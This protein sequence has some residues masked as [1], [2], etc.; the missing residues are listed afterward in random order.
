MCLGLEAIL[1]GRLKQ[2][3]ELFSQ[4]VTICEDRGEQIVVGVTNSLWTHVHLMRGETDRAYALADATLQRVQHAGAGLSLGI[5]QQALG[6]AELA[7][8]K[9]AAAREHLHKAVNTDRYGLIFGFCW[10]LVGL[11][12][13]ERVAGNLQAAHDHGQEALDHARRLGSG[14]MQAGAERLLARLALAA[15]NTS[16]AKRYAGNALMRL[17]V[18]GL[19]LDIP[20]CLD[21]HAA[22]AAAQGD[23]DQAARLFGAA[24]TNRQSLGIIRFPPEPEFWVSVEHTTE[25]AL[26]KDRYRTAYTQGTCGSI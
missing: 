8:G 9:L 14:W 16:E 25:D 21:I 12:A 17:Q 15:G 13:L 26:G 18:K 24:A 20:E 3:S 5:A 7:L 1:H 2:A 6:R 11:G 4:G 22:I 19:A 23:F 10:A